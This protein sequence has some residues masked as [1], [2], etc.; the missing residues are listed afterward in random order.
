M[1]LADARRTM[2]QLAPSGDLGGR[3][4]RSE[5]EEFGKGK[6]AE[7]VLEELSG[8]VSDTSRL[9][10]KP[11]RVAFVRCALAWSSFR[12]LAAAHGSPGRP[13]AA[14]RYSTS[15]EHDAAAAAQ[16]CA[17][18]LDNVASWLLAAKVM[19]PSYGNDT[20]L[21]LVQH[22]A[23]I[24]SRFGQLHYTC[25]SNMAFDEFSRGAQARFSSWSSRAWRR[26]IRS[27]SV[28]LPPSA[29]GSM[30]LRDGCARQ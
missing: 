19:P 23:S 14:I 6:P 1:E 28:R 2:D 3:S 12:P 30:R 5:L 20:W 16:R 24:I 29:G 26:G 15:D 4:L 8:D 9:E 27:L 25:R 10:H 7:T 18:L 17:Q 13:C 21:S 11:L 22:K